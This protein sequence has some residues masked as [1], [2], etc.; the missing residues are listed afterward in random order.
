[1]PT[2]PRPGSGAN[3]AKE[4]ADPRIARSGEAFVTPF[5]INGSPA[6]SIPCGFTKAGAPMGLQLAGRPFEDEL[7]LAAAHRFQTKTEWH[8]RFPSLG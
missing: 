1:M 7:V 3:Y 2:N 4:P 8:R 5:N 6:I